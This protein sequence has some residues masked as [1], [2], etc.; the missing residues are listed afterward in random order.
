M[1]PCFNP[2]AP[3]PSRQLHL[4]LVS[5]LAVAAITSVFLPVSG[6]HLSPATCLASS[7]LHRLSPLRA[8]A[9][10]VAQCGGA[11]LAAALTF[12]LSGATREHFP[13]VRVEDT[14]VEFLLSFLAILVQLQASQ[15]PAQAGMTS[16]LAYASGLSVHRGALNPARALAPALLTNRCQ[17]P[18]T[19]RP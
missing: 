10:T 18:G 13:A 9:M 7:L 3:F 6:A 2:A 14:A 19:C 15:S 11:V 5:G 17:K 8:A 16:G 12:G 4:G 1:L